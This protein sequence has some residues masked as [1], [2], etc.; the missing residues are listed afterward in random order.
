MPVKWRSYSDRTFAGLPL[1]AGVVG[2]VAPFQLLHGLRQGKMTS[3][4]SGQG[5]RLYC[6]L[7][8]PRSRPSPPSVASSRTLFIT[9]TP[10]RPVH[11]LQA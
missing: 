4:R 11:S 10:S 1:V 5:R 8:L 9:R 2:S 3:V 7:R 6:Y